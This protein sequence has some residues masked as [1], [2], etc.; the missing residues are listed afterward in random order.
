MK[1]QKKNPL[2]LNKLQLKT[3]ALTQVLA[4]DPSC[5]IHNETS[6]EI[7]VT[8]L[9]H[10]HGNH[11]HVGAFVVSSRDASGFGNPAVLVALKRKGLV[12]KISQPGGPVV[13]TAAGMAY[14][15]GLG[16]KFLE[17]SDH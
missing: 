1:V 17:P 11:V 4:N 16:D 8:R 6:G 14:D 10:A 2:K 13:L 12:G 3:L 9:P 5:A 7:T 15:T